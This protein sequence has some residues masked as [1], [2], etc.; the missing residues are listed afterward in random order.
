MDRSL[1]TISSVQVFAN[2]K[3][4]LEE[5]VCLDRDKT[6]NDCGSLDASCIRFFKEFAEDN[7]SECSAM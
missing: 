6:L 2:P 5:A 7:G 4:I 3:F 1:A